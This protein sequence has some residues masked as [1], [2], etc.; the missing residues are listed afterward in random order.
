MTDKKPEPGQTLVEHLTELRIRL[1][2]ALMAIAVGT[3]GGWIVSDRLL[4]IVRRP[5]VPYLRGTAKGLVFT[6]VMDDF[7]AHVKVAMMGGVILTCPFWL[8]QIW[9]FIAPGLYSKEK[10]Y[11]AG[12]ILAGSLLFVAGVCFAYFLVY[13]T[14]FKILLN[15][16]GRHDIPMITIREYLSFFFTTTLLFGLAF[17]LP[18]IMTI[19][20]MLGLIDKAFL[21]G[22]RRYAIVLLS[23]IAAILAPPD[24]ISMLLL[25]VPMIGLFEIGVIMVGIFGKKP[26][27]V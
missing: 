26:E 13:P 17:E 23:I 21:T 20:A 3:I 16:G 7:M 10:R 15:F 24:L 8:Y 18:L 6:G 11:S 25:L 1:V 14:A 4:D 22:K 2:R 19:L 9:K 12:F 27:V 5:I